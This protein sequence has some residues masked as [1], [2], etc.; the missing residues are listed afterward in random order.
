MNHLFLTDFLL[1]V[2]DVSAIAL[3]STDKLTYFQRYP[4]Y[5]LKSK[6]N[7]EHLISPSKFGLKPFFTRVCI[8][9]RMS[10]TEQEY[11]EMDALCSLLES[12]PCTIYEITCLVQVKIMF[13]LRMLKALENNVS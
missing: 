7:L 11:Q 10:S 12:K 13:L 6:Y 2:E 1:F 5:T 4:K 3:L 9:D 8:Q